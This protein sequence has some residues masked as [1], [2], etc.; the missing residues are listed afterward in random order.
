MAALLWGLFSRRW[1]DP[2]IAG[3]F[4]PDLYPWALA[5]LRALRDGKSMWNGASSN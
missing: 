4:Y 2:A 1:R 3:R 5:N